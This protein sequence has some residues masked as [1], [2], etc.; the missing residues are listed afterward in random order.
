MLQLEQRGPLVSA[1]NSTAAMLLQ[2]LFQSLVHTLCSA[3]TRASCEPP[4]ARC[5]IATRRVTTPETNAVTAAPLKRAT[6]QLKSDPARFFSGLRPS[7]SARLS[8]ASN[9]RQ[10]RS[11]VCDG[12]N[13]SMK[14]RG[15]NALCVVAA[16][17]SSTVGAPESRLLKRG[18]QRNTVFPES[19][20]VTGTHG[21]LRYP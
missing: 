16:S 17:S 14:Q 2:A 19:N 18:H 12:A 8:L 3:V 6:E 10:P 5:W 9:Q 13:Q 7:S 1:R 21:H 4:Q 15:Q 11:R 20:E